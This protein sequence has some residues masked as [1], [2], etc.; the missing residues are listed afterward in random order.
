MTGPEPHL[1]DLLSALLDGELPA[2]LAEASRQ[3]L[4]GCPACARELAL[5]DAARSRVRALPAVDPPPGFPDRHLGRAGHREPTVGA[6]AVRHRRVGLAALAAGAAAAAAVLGFSSPR[7][8][9]ARPPVSR[10]V[11]V[12]A[13][14]GSGDPVSQLAPAGVPVSFGR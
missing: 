4:S 2:P 1:G 10:L 13:G 3:H 6:A 14:V 8:A 5:V 12:H 9:P 7:E 11:E